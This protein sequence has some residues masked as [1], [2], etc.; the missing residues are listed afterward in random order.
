[1][2]VM[3]E[4]GF[5]SVV[6]HEEVRP[7]IIIVIGGTHREVV[8]L[9]MIDFHGS[10][11][12]GEGPVAVVVIQNR[13]SARIRLRAA[14]RGNAISDRAGAFTVRAEV[15]V[16]A[17]VKI[18]AAVAVI[19]EKCR[20]GM[21]CRSEISP[22]DSRLLGNI[23]EGS[24]PI[25]VIKNVAAILGD[26]KVRVTVVVVISPDTAQPVGSSRHACLFRNVGE[27]SIPVVAI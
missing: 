18:E 8:A 7:A 6:G 12:I 22:R 13:R 5:D 11:D 25:V 27:S 17:Y 10:G 21:K 24:I 4:K 26:V 16:T 14:T 9:R 15:S 2:L 23:G 3:V 1:M 20:A 19:V